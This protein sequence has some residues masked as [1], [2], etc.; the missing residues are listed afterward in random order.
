MDNPGEEEQ[1]TAA[2]YMP[3][4]AES[5][6]ASF[7][8]TDILE[9]IQHRLRREH[10]QTRDGKQVWV[11]RKG[12]K[13]LLNEEGIEDCL[14]MLTS[15]CQRI[16]TLGNIGKHEMPHVMILLRQ[17][18]RNLIRIIA[19]KF[20]KYEIE[21]PTDMFLIFYAVM[22]PLEMSIKHPI[23]GGARNFVKDSVTET[24]ILRE[25]VPPTQE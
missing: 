6:I 21:D 22:N 7:D 18:A 1:F 5:I 14:T 16:T 3:D 19:I 20:S 12:S 24:R 8:Y 10:I 13:P 4:R 17:M 23:G 11:K 9:E 2:P 25:Y 15:L